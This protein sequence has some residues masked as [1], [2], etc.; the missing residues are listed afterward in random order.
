MG[1]GAWSMK[2]GKDKNKIAKAEC[3]KKRN[4]ERRN[5]KPAYPAYPAYRQAGE[6]QSAGRLKYKP[7]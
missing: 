1:H 7:A 2:L 4:S 3:E 6:R 5:S